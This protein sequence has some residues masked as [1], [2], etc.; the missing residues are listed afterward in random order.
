MHQRRQVE[1]E[2]RL[3]PQHR[4]AERPVGQDLPADD[5]DV[6]EARQ[7]QRI[8]PGQD[9]DRHAGDGAARGGAPPDQAAEERRREL[10]DR[11]EG[12]E[13]DAASCASPAER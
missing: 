8:G 13:A 5:A 9:A 1:P 7:Q 10:R 11:G 3:R 2:Q 4:E 6:G 12:Q